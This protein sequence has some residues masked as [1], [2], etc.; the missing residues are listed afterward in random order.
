MSIL[1]LALDA[2]SP[3]ELVKI[4]AQY[5][6]AILELIKL[7]EMHQ[8]DKARAVAIDSFT[9]GLQY[10]RQTSDPTQLADAIRS[11]IT[12]AGVRLP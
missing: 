12:S 4:I 11:H 5:G 1:S 2:F 7:V 8:D 6:P 3:D 9:R 10:A